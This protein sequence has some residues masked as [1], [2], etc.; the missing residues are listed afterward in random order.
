MREEEESIA[1]IQLRVEGPASYC[2]YTKEYIV[3]L[4]L[5]PLYFSLPTD[6]PLRGKI[7]H[8]HTQK[9][10]NDFQL[11]SGPLYQDQPA[12]LLNSL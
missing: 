12:S 3:L 5:K 11:L 8:T 10:F 6:L 9:L 7:T 2:I 4:N 1:G